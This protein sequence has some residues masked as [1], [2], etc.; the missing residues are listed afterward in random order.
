LKILPLACL[1]NK[2]LNVLLNG[3]N[4]GIQYNDI[5]FHSF[6]FLL[7]G[8]GNFAHKNLLSL[9]MRLN[10]TEIENI[11]KLAHLHFGE[12]VQVILFGSRASDEKREGDIDI[13][14]RKKNGEKPDLR[15]SFYDFFTF[16]LLF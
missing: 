8:I 1:W 13:F 14:I 7:W 5:L 6:T 10:E 15:L 12:D 16:I 11:K 2:E 4:S 9:I 3:T